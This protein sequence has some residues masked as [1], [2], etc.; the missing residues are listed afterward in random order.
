MLWLHNGRKETIVDRE[1]REK[2]NG[3]WFEERGE[4]DSRVADRQTEEKR[5]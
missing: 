1:N 5:N 4:E 3:R 2:I